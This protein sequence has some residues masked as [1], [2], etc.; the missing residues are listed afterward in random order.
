MELIVRMNNKVLVELVV[1]TLEERYDIYIPANRK[2][3][4]VIQ[5]CSKAVVDL[6]GNTFVATE[7]NSFYDGD[8]GEKYAYDVLVRDTNIRNGKKIILM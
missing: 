5:L 7:K 3:G 1:P 6:S 4:N 2:V 8:T